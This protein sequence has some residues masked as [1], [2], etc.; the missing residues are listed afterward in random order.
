MRTALVAPI[1]LPSMAGIGCCSDADAVVMN[2]TSAQAAGIGFVTVL[3]C[4]QDQPTVSNLNIRPAR[5]V[6]NLTTVKLSATGTVCLATTSSTH[7]IADVSGYLTDVPVA[8]DALKL[9]S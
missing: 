6:A 1:L 9:V 7:L 4:D 2:V 3:P 5:T 8:G